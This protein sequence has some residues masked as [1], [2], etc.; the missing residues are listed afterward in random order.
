LFYWSIVI[1][2]S[3]TYPEQTIRIDE[4]R[5]AREDMVFRKVTD[6]AQEYFRERGLLG[7]ED[8]QIFGEPPIYRVSERHFDAETTSYLVEPSEAHASNSSDEPLCS[9]PI[10]CS[11]DYLMDEGFSL[12]GRFQAGN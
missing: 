10:V 12:R 6:F 1:L 7:R 9:V 5:Q 2:H 3:S 11:S 4:W 8:Q